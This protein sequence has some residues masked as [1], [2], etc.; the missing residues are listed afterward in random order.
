[1]SY[2]V[3]PDPFHSPTPR[4]FTLTEAERAQLRAFYP[5]TWAPQQGP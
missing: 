1:M 3:R 5:T 2:C 4:F